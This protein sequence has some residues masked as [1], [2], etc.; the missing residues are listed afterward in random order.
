MRLW[1]PRTGQ[2]IYQ[3]NVIK[4]ENTMN[5]WGPRAIAVSSGKGGVGK[6]SLS[7]NLALCFAQMG[8]KVTIF[9]ADLGLANAEVLLGIIPPYSLYEVLYGGMTLE[10]VVIEGP[11]GIRVISGGSGFLEMA[12]LDRSRRQQLLR[13]FNQFIGKDE[14]VLIDTGAGIN[15]NVLGFVAA[16]EDVI[17]VVTPEPTSL[18]DAYALI[19]ILANFKLHS[20]VNIVVNRV[21]DRREATRTMGRIS[22]AT[23]RFLEIKLNFLGWIPEDKH[24]T[25]AVKNQQ[26]YFLTNPNSPASR[27]VAG[28]AASLMEGCLIAPNEGF[29][30]KLMGLFS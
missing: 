12:N 13:M 29:W 3:G 22:N 21:A 28:I 27:S 25:Q 17:I 26:P 24:V 2:A 14:I 7:V 20:E 30:N 8:K 15:K 9:D 5:Y 18:T 6:T 10:E 1:L 11:M 4:S 16:A 19:K 23:G